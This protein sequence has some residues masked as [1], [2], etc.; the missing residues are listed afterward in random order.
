MQ[1]LNLRG[2]GGLKTGKD[3]DG[4]ANW[5]DSLCIR[6]L[7][8]P[9]SEPSFGGKWKSDNDRALFFSCFS[10]EDFAR[11]PERKSF[12]LIVNGGH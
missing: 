4:Q 11:V 5:G 1:W 7:I 2:I 3:Q 12:P 9:V 10:G 8:C 6:S